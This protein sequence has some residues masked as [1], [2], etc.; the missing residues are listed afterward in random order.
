MGALLLFSI[1]LLLR[2]HNLPGGGFTGGLVA[3]AA[4][5]IYAIA[6]NVKCV[7]SALGMDPRIVAMGGVGVAIFAGLIAFVF[8]KPFMT[9]IW[10]VSGDL[11]LG[12]PLLFDVGVYLVVVGSVLTFILGMEEES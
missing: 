5:A 6:Y 3:S 2:G 12:T 8:D 7:R 9:G 11:H 4:F 10:Y 1:F